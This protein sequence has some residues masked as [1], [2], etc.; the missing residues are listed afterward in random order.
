[1][2]ISVFHFPQIPYFH[3]GQK[4]I[5]LTG[6]WSI[7]T[8]KPGFGVEQLLDNQQDTYWQYGF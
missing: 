4:E 5:T 8:C 6:K 3:Q 7:S 1:V 2:S